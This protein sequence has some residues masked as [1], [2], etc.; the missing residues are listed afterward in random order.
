MKTAYLPILSLLLVCN[1]GNAQQN[2]TL[3]AAYNTTVNYYNSVVG[4]N[5]LLYNGIRYLNFPYKSEG[6][7]FYED[8]TW[9]KGH[10]V[11]DGIYYETSLRY[12]LA[13]NAVIV[14]SLEN[15][16]VM[17]SLVKHKLA[18]FGWN[19]HEFVNIQDT[20][21]GLKPGIYER[22]YDGGVTFLSR[23]EK[24]IHEDLSKEIRF[25][26]TENTAYY[27]RKDSEYVRVSTQKGVLDVLADKKKEIQQYLK[28]NDIRFKS[29]KADAMKKIGAYYDQLRNTKS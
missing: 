20:L 25:S 15:N 10:V 14:P 5:V 29:D 28:R 16:V 12:D 23:K 3:N 4:N 17:I 7:P 22:I 1:R 21:P 9:Y 8:D 18:S 24:V 27:I 6:H 13:T 19:D 2:D 11:Y 26:Y